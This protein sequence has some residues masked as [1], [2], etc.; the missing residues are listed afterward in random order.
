MHLMRLQQSGILNC[1]ESIAIRLRL[2]SSHQIVAMDM[3]EV[4]DGNLFVFYLIGQS[5]YNPRVKKLKKLTD[6]LALDYLI[7]IINNLA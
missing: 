5:A 2:V 6:C 3:Q 4:A 1:R 7:W